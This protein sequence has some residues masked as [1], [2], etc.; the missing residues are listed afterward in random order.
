MAFTTDGIVLMADC[1][2]NNKEGYVASS[3]S[4]KPIIGND[5]GKFVQDCANFTLSASNIKTDGAKL[6]AK[7]KKR[8]SDWVADAKLNLDGRIANDD[9][10]LMYTKRCE[11][12]A[13][14][15]L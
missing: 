2:C 14:D 7:V 6:R 5:D 9:G 10:V 15:L 4:L 12:M 8:Y 11:E 13:V 3:I 1:G